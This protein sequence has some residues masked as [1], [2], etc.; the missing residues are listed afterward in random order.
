MLNDVIIN[1][2]QVILKVQFTNILGF[3]ST[4]LLKK[5]QPRY[6]SEKVYIQ[7]IFKR[8]SYWLVAS[9]ALAKR[10]QIIVYNF[11]FDSIH[12]N[13]KEII[14][15]LF[16]PSV[17]PRLAES[18]KQSGGADCGL[19]AIGNA[20]ALA[21]GLNPSQITIDQSVLRRTSAE[22]KQCLAFSMYVLSPLNDSVQEIATS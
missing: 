16:G 13:T 5:E 12:K 17:T 18:S 22:S 3:Q 8:E 2:A 11:I 20:T 4:L 6:Q 21:F 9:N 7:M 1:A 14:E 10:G 15:N 19:Y